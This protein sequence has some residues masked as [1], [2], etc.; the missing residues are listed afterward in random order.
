MT[1]YFRRS[2]AA[3]A[4]VVIGALT[5][6]SPAMAEPPTGDPLN[7][8]IDAN[9]AQGSGQVVLGQGH[10]DIGPTL[11][12]GEWRIQVH[13]DTAKPSQWRML[14]DVVFQVKDA[15]RLQVPESQTYGFLGQKP[16]TEVWVIPQ[17]QKT[18]VIWAG[19]N[20]QEPNVL[21]S[22]K[23]GA[24]FTVQSIQGPG[25]FIV[26]LQSGNFGDPKPLFSSLQPLP[27]QSWIEVNTHTH[28]NWVFSKPGIYLVGIQFEAEL[29]SG[30][31]V[32]A[33]DTLRF[34]VGDAT[35]PQAAF[36]MNLPADQ[37]AASASP[38]A[39]PT[40]PTTANSNSLAIIVWAVVGVIAVA[41]LAAIVIMVTASRRA[42]AQAHAARAQAAGEVKDSTT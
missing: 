3:L 31:K 37:Q 8:T 12:T 18:D 32:T 38:A 7:Q 29:N 23:L 36:T 39:G 24:T 30:Q 28:A 6:L 17:V 25:D 40:A 13:D 1:R 5:I 10:V 20:T 27:Q 2:L 19:W 14:K 26:Y 15:A 16:G 35:D 4:G 33:H 34:A 22:M 11:N 41:L 9:Q 21:S 42:K